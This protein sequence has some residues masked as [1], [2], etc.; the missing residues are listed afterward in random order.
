MKKKILSCTILTVMICTIFTCG[1]ISPEIVSAKEINSSESTR[2]LQDIEFEISKDDIDE[3][4]HFEIEIPQ[5]SETDIEAASRGTISDA[6]Q[7][8]SNAATSSLPSI[9]VEGYAKKNAWTGTV[10]ELG[11][12]C[13]ATGGKI[14]SY[15]GTCTVYKANGITKIKS[16]TF[17]MTNSS[18]TKHLVKQYTFNV[19]NVKSCKVKL[20]NQTS[21]D[22]YGR[23]GSLV[24]YQ[25]GKIKK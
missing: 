3:N 25:T 20:T 21:T 14:K 19:G 1:L 17:S 16:K 11:I 24:S 13:K 22:I 9:V 8:S 7:L 12:G 4:G 5:T 23:T 6:N 10:L 18:G 15:K 2:E